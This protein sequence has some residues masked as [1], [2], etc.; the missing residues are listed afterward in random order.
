[1]ITSSLKSFKNQAFSLAFCCSFSSLYAD[2]IISDDL[3]IQN[4]LGIGMDVFNGEDF[5]FT[6]LLLKENN[7]RIRFN[8]T[9]ASA[10]FPSNDWELT[11]NDTSNGG[12]NRFSISDITGG[13]VPFTVF[14]G[15]RN[16]ALFISGNGDIGFGTSAPAQGLHLTGGDS[17]TIRLEQDGSGGPAAQTWDLGGNEANFFIRDFSNASLI[18]FRVKPSTPNDT[19]SLGLKGV[20]MGINNA[21][22]L[23]HVSEADDVQ[24]A[25]IEN[26]NTTNGARTML[27]LRNAGPTSLQISNATT[28]GTASDWDLTVDDAG[29]LLIQRGGATLVTIDA[30]GNLTASGTVNG[31]SDLN[32]KENFGEVDNGAL[33]EKVSSIPVRSWSY[34]GEN[35]TH[36]GPMAQD[37]YQA[38]ALGVSDRQISMADADGVALASIQALHAESKAKDRKIADLE[39]RLQKLEGLLKGA[40]E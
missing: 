33:L 17:P 11:A 3:I 21:S 39:I 2:Q 6:T 14:A 1:M 40:A 16:D 24:A 20:G 12:A 9:S 28:S 7:L 25:L 37:F 31:S 27:Q 30:T 18:P 4:S 10:S 13:R 8:D 36:I 38:F 15:A 32:R 23:L 26:T 34:K 5:G 19:L 29:S 22:H 35:V